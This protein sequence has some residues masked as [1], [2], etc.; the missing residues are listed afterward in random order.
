MHNP[1]VRSGISTRQRSSLT[2]ECQ[3]FYSS[4]TNTL[5]LKI[6]PIVIA[7]AALLSAVG[8]ISSVKQV[9]K[10]LSQSAG[11]SK[12]RTTLDDNRIVPELIHSIEIPK[13]KQLLRNQK[14]T[15]LGNQEKD[16]Q[17]LTKSRRISDLKPSERNPAK[18]TEI[19]SEFTSKTFVNDKK[20]K[21]ANL[22]SATKAI[23]TD[24]QKRHSG[25]IDIQRSMREKMKAGKTDTAA[26]RRKSP[27]STL[28]SNLLPSIKVGTSRKLKSK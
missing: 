10:L 8:M 17:V 12:Q 28:K 20:T 26:Q 14:P 16:I 27:Q 4:T 2:S 24:Y 21:Q 19:S 9:R 23:L 25:E 1:Q 7:A 13:E 15:I 5:V 22:D 3:Q 11:N 6:D 18:N